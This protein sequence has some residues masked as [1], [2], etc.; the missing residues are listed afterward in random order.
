MGIGNSGEPFPIAN[1]GV[2]EKKNNPD[3]KQTYGFRN[4]ADECAAQV[5]P[6]FGPPTY[7]GIVET[8]PYATLHDRRHD[9][10][11]R[12]RGQRDLRD[13]AAGQGHDRR[14]AAA[15]AGEDHR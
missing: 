5:P 10:R 14:G 11:R 9:V 2:Y 6:Q 13:P 8:H 7:K 12:R 1:L 15:G 4:L 3:G